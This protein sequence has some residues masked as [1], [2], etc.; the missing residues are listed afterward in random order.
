M[1]QL[2]Q[3]ILD[4]KSGAVCIKYKYN[5]GE[6]GLAMKKLTKR[7]GTLLDMLSAADELID[8]GADH[9]IL[10]AYA[11]QS[12]KA[13]HATA[14]D[15]SAASL[16]KARALIK[17]L[18]LEAKVGFAVSDGFNAIT[19][20]GGKYCAVIAG[21]GGELIA[22]IL[23]AAG[24][25]AQ[26][27]AQIAMQPMGGAKELRAYLYSGGFCIDDERIIKETG[28]YY[29]LILAH[30]DGLQ[31]PLPNAGL[32]EFGPIAYAQRQAELK[33]LLEKICATRRAKLAKAQAQNAAP[34]E[35]INELEYAQALLGNW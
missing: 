20:P 29:Q 2:G 26:Q 22:D 30:Y 19:M 17:E 8:I 21:M 6:G 32:L 11:V 24:A 34:Q 13:A 35:L 16:S 31:R 18:E 23:C 27:A 1:L 7:L 4:C 33:A 9:G 25:K 28:R 10:C 15:I 14:A 12:G 3:N 5:K